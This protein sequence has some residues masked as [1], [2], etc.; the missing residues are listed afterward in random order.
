MDRVNQLVMA[1]RPFREAYQEVAR[2][3]RQQ[4]FVPEEKLTHT[5]EGS[6]GNL[7]LE[8]IQ[9]KMN[10]RMGSFPF[11]RMDNAFRQLLEDS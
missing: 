11:D 1:G 4:T 5:H 7:C 9:R 2:Q 6:L 10:E 3:I 8:D